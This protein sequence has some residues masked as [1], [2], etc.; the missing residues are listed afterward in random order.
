MTTDEVLALL[1]QIESQGVVALGRSWGDVYAGIVTFRVADGVRVEVFN[2]CDDWD[3]V[4]EIF[5]ADGASI[6]Q[7]PDD[8]NTDSMRVANWKPQDQRRWKLA[9]V[10]KVSP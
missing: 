1:R 5:D 9:P 7:I 10:V 8:Q 2:D 4:A 3:Y 6:W